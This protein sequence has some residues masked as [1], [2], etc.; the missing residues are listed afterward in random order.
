M[1]KENIVLAHQNTSRGSPSNRGFEDRTERRSLCNPHFRLQSHTQSVPGSQGNSGLG[2][3]RMAGDESETVALRDH[4]QDQ[5][6]F[7]HREILAD[8]LPLAAPE[9]EVRMLRPTGGAFRK[10]ALGI[11]CFGIVPEFRMAGPRTRGYDE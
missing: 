7:H 5:Q 9:G 8:A 6:R 4:S 3:D 2:L 11:E 10:E 1:P